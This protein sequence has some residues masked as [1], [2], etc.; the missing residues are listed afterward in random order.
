MTTLSARGQAEPRKC[1][2]ARSTH[3]LSPGNAFNPLAYDPGTLLP[4]SW[5]AQASVQL[6][7]WSLEVWLCLRLC[8]PPATSGTQRPAF[9]SRGGGLQSRSHAR[10]VP[11]GH[12][13][14][15]TWHVTA[16]RMRCCVCSANSRA[17]MWGSLG[18]GGLMWGA[19]EQLRRGLGNCASHQHLEGVR[20][21]EPRVQR[22][23]S[24]E[25][26]NVFWGFA[27]LALSSCRL[28]LDR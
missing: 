18:W 28:F 1:A 24:E 6:A 8:R 20:C 9:R 25:G 16:P 27:G 12:S 26:R 5:S 22:A 13:P 21:H 15:E 23:G 3:G 17:R 14:A 7:A 11:P 2:R 4:P 10:P 19:P